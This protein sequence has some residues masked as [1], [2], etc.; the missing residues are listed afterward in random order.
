MNKTEINEQITELLDSLDDVLD[1][2]FTH[3]SRNSK[4]QK[5]VI[6]RFK[7][8]LEELEVLEMKKRVQNKI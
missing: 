8:K 7:N 3:L 6:A 5:E 4:K 2:Y 1:N